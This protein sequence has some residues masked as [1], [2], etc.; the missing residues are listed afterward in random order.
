MDVRSI[1]LGFLMYGNQTGYNLRKLFS[2]SFSFFSGLSYG[3]IYPALKKMEQEGLI[4]MKMEIQDGTPNRK[5]YTITDAGRSFF[6]NALKEPVPFERPKNSFLMRLFFFSFLPPSDRLKAARQY[7]A[8]IRKL[9]EELE[10]SRGEIEFTADEYQKLCFN[11]GKHY[12]EDM[13]ARISEIITF[14]ENME[15][16][17]AAGYKTNHQERK[18]SMASSQGDLPDL[19]EDD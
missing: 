9:D 18:A 7:L 5:V 1:I 13:I 8:D 16:E 15:K 6:T 2:I 10:S 4:T 17:Q 12:Y 19:F 14:L 3:S 11:L